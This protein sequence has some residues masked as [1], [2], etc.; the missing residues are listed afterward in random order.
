MPVI[1]K[2][3]TPDERLKYIYGMIKVDMK[4]IEL[5]FYQ[6]ELI[7]SNAKYLS[8][9]KARQIGWSF[10]LALKG[11]AMANDPARIKY[12]KQFVSYNE[13]DA[14]E[15]IRY[16]TEFYDSIPVKYRKKLRH[17]TSTSMEFIDAGGKTTSRLI[18]I[19]C[20]PP[21]GKNGDIS[22]DEMAFYPINRVS[23]IYTAGVNA[24][25]RGGHIEVGSTPFGT[26]GTFYDIC[27]NKEKY[28]NYVRYNIPWWYSQHH[29]NDVEK[30]VE[31]APEMSTEERVRKFGTE[32]LVSIYEANLLEEFQQEQECKFIDS[33]SSYIPLELI[34]A[35]TPGLR[36]GNSLSR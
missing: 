32:T 15:K 30:A 33:K 19:A 17:R 14:R 4:D 5:D 34:Y 1:G 24:I 36:E 12:T 13:E 9:L 26:I 27:T 7:R 28:K 11:L 3:W 31:L 22:F 20:R 25:V 10:L 23:A 29:C 35:N 6:E 8:T 21:R 2:V 18:S 16:A